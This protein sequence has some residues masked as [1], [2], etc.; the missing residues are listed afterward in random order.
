LAGLQQV[1]ERTW[2]FDYLEE[3]R[4]AGGYDATKGKSLDESLCDGVGLI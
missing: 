1:F 4:Q 3:G 2:K